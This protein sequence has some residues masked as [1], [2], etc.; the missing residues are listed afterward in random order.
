MEHVL[1][2]PH[3]DH[4]QCWHQQVNILIKWLKD[5]DTHPGITLIFEQVLSSHGTLSFSSQVPPPLMAAATSQARIGLF[6]LMTGRLSSLWLPVQAMHYHSSNSSRLAMVWAKRLCQ[7]LIQF[8]HTIWVAQNQQTKALHS[9]QEVLQVD[10][11]IRHQFELGT[12]NVPPTDHF[13]VVQEP[14]TT[15]LILPLS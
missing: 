10:A 5:T 2:C 7:Q 14:R 6:G 13:Y 4:S 15:A 1:L 11:D 9:A 3:P 8:L 12:Q